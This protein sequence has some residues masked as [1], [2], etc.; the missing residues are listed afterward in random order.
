MLSS[1][2]EYHHQTILMFSGDLALR[3]KIWQQI[4]AEAL[5]R[6]HIALSSKIGILIAV[7]QSPITHVC[8]SGTLLSSCAAVTE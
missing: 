3:H 1:H 2:T 5:S 8:H 7:W 6:C 4:T